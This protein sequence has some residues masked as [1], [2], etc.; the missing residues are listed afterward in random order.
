MKNTL[1]LGLVLCCSFVSFAQ[2][3][4]E[5]KDTD[6]SWQFD[7]A[8]YMWFAGIEGEISFLNQTAPVMAEFSDIWANLSFG[9]M[10]HAEAT[11]GKWII[12]S[13]L[14][15]IKL[16]K[17]G[18][19]EPAGIDTQVEIEEIIAEIGGGYNLVNTD[20][21]LFV[22][23]IVGLRYFGLDTTLDVDQVRVFDRLINVND[24]F[25]GVRIRTNSEKWISSAR[26]DVGGFGI[27]SEFS[28]KANVYVGYRF[29]DL[30]SLHLG[31][32]AYGLD[33]EKGN[34]SM[35]TT[36]AGF[37]TGFNFHL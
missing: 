23:G 7:V 36:T 12:M 26:V 25:V 15:Y 27:G 2:T 1:L 35:N 11:K 16:S 19:L 20:D 9:F 18:R 29:S 13:D 8:P 3:E 33:Y 24:P 5:N 6:Q 14:V 34:L 21:W 17:D 32:N 22:D 10:A 31:Y 4:T 37:V 30:F 28:W